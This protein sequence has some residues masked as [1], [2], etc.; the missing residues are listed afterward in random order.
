MPQTLGGHA[1]SGS[2]V[3][4]VPHRRAASASFPVF[5]AVRELLLGPPGCR[6]LAAPTPEI[7]AISK[8]WRQVSNLPPHVETGSSYLPGRKVLR[9]GQR[10]FGFLGRP[11]EFRH[12]R[13]KC[14]VVYTPVTLGP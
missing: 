13:P 8:M 7:G 3:P 6:P 5:S 10:C 4:A 11:S 14:G 2:S 1:C 12:G 9:N